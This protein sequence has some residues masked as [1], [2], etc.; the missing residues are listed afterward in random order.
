M[1]Q[2]NEDPQDYKDKITDV[3]KKIAELKKFIVRRGIP[4]LPKDLRVPFS[5]CAVRREGEDVTIVAWGRAV[6]TALKAADTLADQGIS[7]EVLDLRTLVPPDLEGIY[8]SIEK[9]GRLVVA[10]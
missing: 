4:D 9:T 5:K 1:K 10:A 2:Q 8:A 3:T 6:W 7:A